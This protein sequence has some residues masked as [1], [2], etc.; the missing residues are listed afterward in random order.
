MSLTIGPPGASVR[1]AGEYDRDGRR[2]FVLL[3]TTP[4]PAQLTPRAARQVAAALIRFSQSEGRDVMNEV[5]E[6]TE[7]LFRAVMNGSAKVT[8]QKPRKRPVVRERV[9]TA[10][11]LAEEQRRW[12]AAKG[13]RLGGTDGGTLH[14][15]ESQ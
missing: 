12:L 9:A 5:R 13:R 14:D 15:A 2:G 3:A 1:V 6:D 7:R 11:E 4:N 8:R 10:A